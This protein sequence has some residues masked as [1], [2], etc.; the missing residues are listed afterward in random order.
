MLNYSNNE[1]LTYV[2]SNDFEVEFTTPTV[3][4]EI[5]TTPVSGGGGAKRPVSLKIILPEVRTD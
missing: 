1:S 5:V 4:T 3:E 2:D